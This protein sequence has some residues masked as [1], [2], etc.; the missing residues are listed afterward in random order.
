MHFAPVPLRRAIFTG[1]P[2]EST[3]P[4]PGTDTLSF[5]LLLAAHYGGQFVACP[6]TQQTPTL[7]NGFISEI[8]RVAYSRVRERSTTLLLMLPM[9]GMVTVTSSPGLRYS[10]GFLA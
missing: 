5:P 4:G 9:A 2:R 1:A 8:R 7:R 3:P 6:P 10:G